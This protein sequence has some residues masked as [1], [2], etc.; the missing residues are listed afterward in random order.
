V[1]EFNKCFSIVDTCLSCEDSLTK[2]C[3]GDLHPKLALRPHHV[4]KMV[5]I[6]SATAENR[7]GKK[8]K[9]RMWADAQRDGRPAEYSWKPVLDAANLARAHCSTAVQ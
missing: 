6:Q 2:V 8:R 9:N 7:Q 1:W 5:D 3:D 4:W